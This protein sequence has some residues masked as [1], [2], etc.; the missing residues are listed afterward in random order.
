VSATTARTT[1]VTERLVGARVGRREEINGYVFWGLVALFIGVPEL[2]AAFSSTLKADI[3]WPTISN[4]V[5]KDLE[6]HH[7]WVALLVVGLIVVVTAHTLTY[8]AAKKKAG[9]PVRHPS[10][11]V[12]VSWSEWYI[13]VVAAAGAAAGFIASASGANKNELGYAIYGTLTVF[14]I[15]VPSVLAYW[16][17]RVLALPTLFATLACLRARAAWVAALVLASLVVLLFHLALYP[18]PNSQ[19]GG[20]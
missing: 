16:W 9:R 1:P 15:V 10:T 19:F 8:P 18:W 13:V 7:P 20:P 14:G 17:N 6:R 2:L 4:L 12:H 3:P 11:A 5:G